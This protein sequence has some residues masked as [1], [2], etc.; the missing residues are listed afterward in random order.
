MAPN[1][2]SEACFEILGGFDVRG[3]YFRAGGPEIA[4]Q[5]AVGSVQNEM[6]VRAIL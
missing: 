1:G 4:V 2:E 5:R 6:A 3:G